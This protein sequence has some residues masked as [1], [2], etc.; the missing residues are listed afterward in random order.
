MCNPPNPAARNA[1]PGA[2]GQSSATVPTAMK[3]A[4]IIGT[5]RTEDQPPREHGSSVKQQPHARQKL[6][7]PRAEQNR[8]Q[9]H[10]RNHCGREPGDEFPPRTRQQRHAGTP[11]LHGRPK[12]PDQQRQNRLRQPDHQPARVRRSRPRDPGGRQRRRPHQHAAQPRH[13]RKRPRL[14]DSAADVPQVV[15]CVSVK[16]NRFGP[17]RR[18]WNPAYPTG[19][20][21]SSTFRN[22]VARPLAAKLSAA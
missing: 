21:F 22:K 18:H 1:S 11:R 6:A 13:R 15:H 12:N 19:E 9:Y 10:P 5:T 8:A 2:A 14:F 16:L 17:C 4:P 7:Q 20:Y 3:Q